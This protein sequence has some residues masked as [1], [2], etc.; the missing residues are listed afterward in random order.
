MIENHIKSLTVKDYNKTKR[1]KSS[2]ERIIVTGNIKLP[3]GHLLA[4]EIYIICL[5]DGMQ[6]KLSYRSFIY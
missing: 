3:V 6:F 2:E 4:E 1:A 5:L